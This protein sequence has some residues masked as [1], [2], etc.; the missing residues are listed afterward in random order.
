MNSFYN[1]NNYKKLFNISLF[2]IVIGGILAIIEFLT[3]NST[4]ILVAG[5]VLLFVLK[6]L[7]SKFY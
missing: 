6:I 5:I 3:E 4:S 2:L 7:Q 1:Q